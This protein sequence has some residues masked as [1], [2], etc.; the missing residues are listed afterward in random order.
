MPVL[1]GRVRLG[2]TFYGS[3]NKA[4]MYSQRFASGHPRNTTVTCR[5]AARVHTYIRFIKV[6]FCCPEKS[7]V[8]HLLLFSAAT[9]RPGFVFCHLFGQINHWPGFRPLAGPG[10]RPN[11]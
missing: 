6:I 2:W 7:F 11:C 4:Y 5:A 3:G 8:D 10:L 9:G 1:A